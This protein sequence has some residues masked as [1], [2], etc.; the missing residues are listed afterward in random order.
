MNTQ[1]LDLN[2][3][4]LTSISVID[5]EEIN[6]GEWASWLKGLSVAVIGKEIIDHWD[7][8]K[9]GLKAGWNGLH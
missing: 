8:I 1:T 3:M 9:S 4:G 6:G 7:E 2:R 5:T